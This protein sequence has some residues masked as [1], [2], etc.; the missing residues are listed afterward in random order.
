MTASRPA[1]PAG[2]DDRPAR[3]ALLLSRTAAGRRGGLTPQLAADAAALSAARA[4]GPAPVR[5][6]VL[7]R[8]PDP[9][10]IAL[11]AGDLD[12][13]TVTGPGEPEVLPLRHAPDEGPPRLSLGPGQRAL[14]D[15]LAARAAA[16]ELPPA[17]GA[18]VR[19]CRRAGRPCFS[20]EPEDFG[21][22]AGTAAVWRRIQDLA[23]HVAAGQGRDGEPADLEPLFAEP[24]VRR[25]RT[26][27]PLLLGDRAVPVDLLDIPAGLPGRAADATGAVRR[28]AGACHAVLLLFPVS[29]LPAL[30]ARP[31]GPEPWGGPVPRGPGPADPDGDLTWLRSWTDALR[32]YPHGPR[33]AY[34][35]LAARPRSTVA[36]PDLAGWLS[37]RL[38]V[39]LGTPH[40]RCPTYALAVAQ[41]L[42]AARIEAAPGRATAALVEQAR[43][44]RIDCG[45]AALADGLTALVRACAETL[46]ELTRRRL[47][48]A[49]DDTRMGCRDTAFARGWPLAP[50][51]GATPAPTPSRASDTEPERERERVRDR[52]CGRDRGSG[53]DEL[54]DRFETYAVGL[55][56]D[57]AARPAGRPAGSAG[58][59]PA[60]TPRPQ[61]GRQE[62]RREDLS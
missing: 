57:R 59:R 39:V 43:A 54:W 53:S 31:P 47:T 20:P 50:L 26:S 5:I 56:A 7:R 23:R 1:E 18:W 11:L 19:A 40:V 42:R 62:S 14:L 30:P 17:T 37:G 22:V 61:D 41:A 45:T 35:A 55:A 51:D 25:G 4:P 13:G 48:A 16:H 33:R 52:G 29:A 32:T 28:L 10:V 8:G 44:D 2:P 58:R 12:G 36:M 38:P 27:G 6:G 21:G 60:F 3:A 15:R 49:F 34:L 46:P 9:G 24:V